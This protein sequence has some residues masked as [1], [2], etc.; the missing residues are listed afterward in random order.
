MNG[1]TNVII[2]IVHTLLV[3]LVYVA[4]VIV[5]HIGSDDQEYKLIYNV[6][7]YMPSNIYCG[8]KAV[9]K[10]K[11]LGTEKECIDARQVR[12]YGKVSADP[13]HFIIHPRV[14]KAKK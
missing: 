12:H 6:N 9:P 7:I 11:H 13:S 1:L 4:N 14:A 2:A 3:G 10:N 8:V 5:K